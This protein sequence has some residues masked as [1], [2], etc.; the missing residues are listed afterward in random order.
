M[1]NERLRHYF[2]RQKGKNYFA[3][4]NT[5]NQEKTSA[6]SFSSA[7]KKAKLLE[8]GYQDCKELYSD[9]YSD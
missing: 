6:P 2:V 8:I 5:C 3:V 1:K 7:I 9:L 4:V